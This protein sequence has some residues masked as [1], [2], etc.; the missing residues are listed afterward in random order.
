M[1]LTFGAV[2]R[3]EHV[4]AA[5]DIGVEDRVPRT[6]DGMAAEMHDAVDAGDDFFDVGHLGEVG[7][8]EGFIGARD[9]RAS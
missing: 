9:R 8:H 7:G 5:D 3:L 1:R 6:F 2:S 4:V